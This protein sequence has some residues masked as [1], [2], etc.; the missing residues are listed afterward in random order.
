M[1]INLRLGIIGLTLCLSVPSFAKEHTV[2]SPD[3]K[4]VVTISDEQGK[5]TYTV[6]YLTDEFIHPSPLGLNTNIG[7]FTK[8]MTLRENT[9]V[10]EIKENYSLATIKQS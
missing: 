3:G 9:T 4:I 2:K 6:N 5:P 1:K 10:N 8:G 7:D